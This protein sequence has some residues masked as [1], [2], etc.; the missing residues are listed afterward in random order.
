MYFRSWQCFLRP[1]VSHFFHGVVIFTL[2]F[3]HKQLD[4]TTTLNICS[5]NYN[6]LKLKARATRFKITHFLFLLIKIVN[7]DSNKQIE[8]KK[9]AKYDEKNKIDEHIDILLSS[10]LLIKLQTKTKK[11]SFF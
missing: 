9:R 3:C 10:W 11:N 6:Y 5:L 4:R 2:L 7:N 8:G 1:F